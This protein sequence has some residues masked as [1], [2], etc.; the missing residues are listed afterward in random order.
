[1]LFA[2]ANRDE[3]K[4]GPD[5][6]TYRLDRNPTDH[7]GFGH[8]IHLCLGAPLARLEARVTAELLFEQTSAF[9]PSGAIVGTQIF[10]L[11]GCTSIP[12]TVIAGRCHSRS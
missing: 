12:L 11:R 9:E 6:A 3:E 4:W 10:L 7:V 2:A 1:M 5:A 8:G